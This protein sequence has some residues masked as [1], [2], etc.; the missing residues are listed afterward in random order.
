MS[1]VNIVQSTKLIISLNSAIRFYLNISK[2]PGNNSSAHTLHIHI[3]WRATEQASPT[4]AHKIPRRKRRRNAA[5]IIRFGSQS[6][7][8][9]NK[10]I[11]TVT[12][13]VSDTTIIIYWRLDKL[14]N[15]CYSL[16]SGKKQ[17][18]HILHRYVCLSASSE[19]RALAVIISLA[20]QYRFQINL[21]LACSLCSHSPKNNIRASVLND[22][23]FRDRSINIVC[24]SISLT[25]VLI[26][27]DSFS[28][29]PSCHKIDILKIHVHRSSDT[30][31]IA[32]IK[33][34]FKFNCN[35]LRFVCGKQF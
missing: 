5:R 28:F 35:G 9:N 25:I 27:M 14:L 21:L 18:Q 22:S 20:Q 4:K 29:S 11:H 15:E 17:Q 16:N 23:T 12:A 2:Q 33:N 10:S 32:W 31:P 1:A 30:R 24:V 34:C 7:E 13:G 3:R 19:P 6:Q 26:K 8:S